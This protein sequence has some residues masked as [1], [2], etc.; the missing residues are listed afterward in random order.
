[1]FPHSLLSLGRNGPYTLIQIKLRPPRIECLV[2]SG[3]RRNCKFHGASRD[4]FLRTKCSPTGYAAPEDA[5]ARVEFLL[6]SRHQHT[7]RSLSAVRVCHQVSSAPC[8]HG[9][10]RKVHRSLEHMGLSALCS[11][12]HT[13]IFEPLPRAESPSLLVLLGIGAGSPTPQSALSV[14]EYR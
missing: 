1:M 2:G 11:P 9:G 6:L 8:D 10:T 3:R 14:R 4:A 5:R 7:S 13:D 12:L